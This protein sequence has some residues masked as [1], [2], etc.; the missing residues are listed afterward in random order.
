MSRFLVTCIALLL[1]GTPNLRAS[2]S[3]FSD[4]HRFIFFTVLEGLYNDGL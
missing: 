2:D 1:L 4:T 3:M